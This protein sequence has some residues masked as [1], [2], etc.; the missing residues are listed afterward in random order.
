MPTSLFDQFP[1]D[2]V[3]RHAIRLAVAADVAWSLVGDFGD[4]RVGTG[5]VER[6]E[7]EGRGVGAIRSLHLGNGVVIR[8]RLEEHSDSDRR[9]VYRVVDSGPFDFTHYLATASVQAAGP[10]ECIL[11]WITMATAV[12]GQH[13]QVRK[14]LDTNIV[15]VFAAVR[16]ELGLGA[17]N[18]ESPAQ[19]SSFASGSPSAVRSSTARA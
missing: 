15:T 12:D 11:T 19:G 2:I 10:N 6:I 13:D 14:L 18:D 4:Q 16:R 5:L 8:E 3:C 7:V 1:R 9:Y 17:A